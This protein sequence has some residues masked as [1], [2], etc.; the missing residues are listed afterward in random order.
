MGSEELGPSVEEKKTDSKDFDTAH[1]V[2]GVDTEAEA[3]RTR[4]GGC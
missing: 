4:L 1:L 2:K 3:Q